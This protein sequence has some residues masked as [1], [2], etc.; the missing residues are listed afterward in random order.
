M[1]GSP[2]PPRGPEPEAGK[3]SSPSAGTSG[4]GQAHHLIEQIARPP[5]VQ[6]TDGEGIAEASET[7]SHVGRLPVG[8]VDL[9]DDQQRVGPRRITLAAARSSSVTPVVTSTT[10]STTSASASARSACSV[11]FGLKGVAG[12]AN[13]PPVSIHGERNPGPARPSA[14]CG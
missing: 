8:V 5:T 4:G 11:T 1:P 2:P 3:P 6:R 12:P 9:V 10:M 14:P 13:H 7:N